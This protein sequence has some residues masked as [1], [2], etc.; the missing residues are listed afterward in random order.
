M[1][2]YFPHFPRVNF[3]DVSVERAFLLDSMVALRSHVIRKSYLVIAHDG[4]DK[5]HTVPNENGAIK[6]MIPHVALNAGK[7]MAEDV[8]RHI[9]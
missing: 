9:A 3:V 6:P 7:R 8:T 1:S 2:T 5:E 4:L